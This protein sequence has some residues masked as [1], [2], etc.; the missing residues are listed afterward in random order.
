M[1]HPRIVVLSG[2][3]ASG[4]TGLALELSREFGMEIVSADSMQVYRRFDIGTAKPTR[5][6]RE[7]VPHHLIDV[8]DPD[9]PYNVG[10]YVEEAETAIAGIVSRG[11]TPLVVG[12][13]G[14]YLR[15][16][17]RGLDPMPS[18]PAVR[19]ALDRSWE[20]EGGDILYAELSRVDPETASR[21][22]PSDRHRVVRA[23]EIAAIG[24]IPA[25][26][27][28]SSWACASKKYES[29][30]LV[31]WPYREELYR[32]I[33]AR[34]ERMFQAG[35][36]NEVS[37][38]LEAGYDRELKP[39]RSLGYRQAAAHLLDA[40]PLTEAVESTKRDT[41]RYAKRQLTWLS[42]EPESIRIAP[43]SALR[44]EAVRLVNMFL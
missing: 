3:T 28:R 20:E 7:G 44:R 21:V 4:K 34:T 10:K 5:E 33:E 38:L 24:G 14:M 15:A 41:R 31:L 43:E 29:L 30:F 25:G 16:L 18:D 36:V 1:S 35:L 13:T 42:A 17:L 22:H 6:E 8:A 12:G 39:M 9:E 37:E 2:P 11:K 23:L 32:N 40:L 27:A 26:R 19:A